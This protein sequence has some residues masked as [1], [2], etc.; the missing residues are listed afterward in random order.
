LVHSSVVDF[1]KYKKKLI[2]SK[3]NSW[4]ITDEMNYYFNKEENSNVEMR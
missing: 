3:E 1:A 2:F 4:Y